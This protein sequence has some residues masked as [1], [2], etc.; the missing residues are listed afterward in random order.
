MRFPFSY[1]KSKVLQALRY[2]FIWQQEIKIML[3]VIIVFD[4]ISAILYYSGKIRPEPFMLG[5][6]IWLFFIVTIW[7][8]LPNNIFRKS[9]TFKEKYII[10]FSGVG[11]HLETEKGAGQWQWK[12]FNKYAESPHFFH[13][14]FSQKS[15]F[16]VP[17]D[18]INADM[19]TGIR[20][21]LKENIK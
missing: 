7:Y 4:I 2:H 5:S 3:I 15:F 21:L 16:L 9:T 1:D 20:S 18:G 11:V 14:Y 13:L 10:S 12:D 17:K 6:V 8:L 19:I